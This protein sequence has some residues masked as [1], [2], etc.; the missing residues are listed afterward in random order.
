MA[1]S[2][3]L[4]MTLRNKGLL[5][6]KASNTSASGRTNTAFYEATDAYPN[7]QYPDLKPRGADRFDCRCDAIGRDDPLAGCTPIV[8]QAL[9]VN[10]LADGQPTR[11]P[12]RKYGG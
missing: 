11:Y 8:S 5:E 9:A 1:K 12:S 3:I 2:G 6:L 7:R 10:W 4:K